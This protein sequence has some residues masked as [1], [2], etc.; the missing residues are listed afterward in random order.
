[1]SCSG[2]FFPAVSIVSPLDEIRI[3]AGGSTERDT[4]ALPWFVDLM[5]TS[6]TLA[7]RLASTMV[8][9]EPMDSSEAEL[10]PWLKSPLLSAGLEES[11]GDKIS[12]DDASV[13]SD[14]D[15]NTFILPM[16]WD[17]A[18]RSASNSSDR[19]S[20]DPPV[21]PSSPMRDGS[22][23]K[24]K[25]AL[26]R[27]RNKFLQ[28]LVVDEERGEDGSS[29][30]A[31]VNLF[32]LWLARHGKRRKHKA[33]PSIERLFVAVLLKHSGLWEEAA[34]V[35][36]KLRKAK[37]ASE[38]AIG[39]AAMKSMWSIVLRMRNQLRRR[40]QMF[41]ASAL[42]AD[43]VATTGESKASVD[44]V[45]REAST[46]TNDSEGI[47]AAS[48]ETFK[49]RSFMQDVPK[50]FDE[51]CS[52]LCGRARL[53]LQIVPCSMQD[54]DEKKSASVSQMAAKWQ[55]LLPT[56]VLEPL[57]KRW[58]SVEKSTDK[59]RGVVSVLR[60]QNKLLKISG[61]SPGARNDNEEEEEESDITARDGGPTRMPEVSAMEACNLYI[62]STDI[63]P[64][65]LRRLLARLRRR[66][67]SRMY[68]MNAFLSL[69]QATRPRVRGEVTES[70]QL[71]TSS[72]SC[73][74]TLVWLRSGF[75][76]AKT[77]RH[78][79]G[80]ERLSERH[81]YLKGLEGCT[82][83]VVDRVQAVFLQLYTE[84]N[85][86]LKYAVEHVEAEL[87]HVAMW[88]WSLDL[89]NRDHEFIA[90]L[91]LLSQ[92]KK[93]FS[94]RRTC[95]KGDAGGTETSRSVSGYE[96]Y[97]EKWSPWTV[98]SVRRRLLSGDLTRRCLVTHMRSAPRTLVD[99][100]WF[101]ERRLEGSPE[102]V[103]TRVETSYLLLVYE[104]FVRQILIQYLRS[105]RG[106][107]SENTRVLEKKQID[108]DDASTAI[109][110]SVRTRR[111]QKFAII[112]RG[113]WTLFRLL[114]TMCAGGAQGRR[115]AEGAAQKKLS[116]SAGVPA[117]PPKPASLKREKSQF[118]TP[119]VQ[120]LRYSL[121]IQQEFFVT[122]T[123]ELHYGLSLLSRRD[124][125]SCE[126]LE[127]DRWL[128]EHARSLLSLSNTT[129]GT[130]ALSKPLFLKSVFALSFCGSPALQR[131]CLRLLSA[132]LS[133]L[134]P[135]DLGATLRDDCVSLV[136]AEGHSVTKKDKGDSLLVRV[137]MLRVSRLF[138][139]RIASDVRDGSNACP[140]F[141][142]FYVGRIDMN[143]AAES[144]ALLQELILSEHWHDTV[145]DLFRKV[146]ENCTEDNAKLVAATLAVIGGYDCLRIG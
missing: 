118:G 38:V 20:T 140:A 63:C 144:I 141:R 133:Q 15:R 126:R 135:S 82:S 22:R 75:R 142:G 31:V 122:V 12:N 11:A 127:I 92:L 113:A 139:A 121:A 35:M 40:K 55:T 134:R 51:Y 57:L 131:L 108:A 138:C 116:D 21:L 99:D 79:P 66:A 23:V 123:Q 16:S 125:L 9:A 103:A 132:S 1:M 8:A 53:L 44:D 85:G 86:I 47:E 124:R 5:R 3:T 78:F 46:K 117:A 102:Q 71:P 91:G 89:E 77:Y 97:A 115:D 52:Q 67:L 84:V 101:K 95:S 112:Q 64:A 114:G 81:H 4:L 88:C 128:C 28:S 110:H 109:A 48:E 73:V 18:C 106:L 90:R 70:V 24:S 36:T 60:T 143:I 56:P 130:L 13:A 34:R 6:T 137:L 19:D 93:I 25:P 45:T 43:D 105:H 58:K 104:Q 32:M 100:V 59:W 111:M 29:N 120:T 107:L 83:A 136:V 30:A 41:N 7:A 26:V 76:G 37:N 33:F 49:R 74:E 68:G 17:E 61:G 42:D 129:P 146:L 94:L 87:A 39:S 2:P 62:F 119:T 50:T 69:L 72:A 14:S 145:V 65:F 96:V 10:E 80:R 98:A 54:I 27:V